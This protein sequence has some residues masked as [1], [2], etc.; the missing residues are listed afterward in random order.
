MLTYF[1]VIIEE[2]DPV[3]RATK[4]IQVYYK[5]KILLKIQEY[6][7]LKYFVCV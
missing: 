3:L 7:C 2:T 5:L 1:F 6:F 4:I